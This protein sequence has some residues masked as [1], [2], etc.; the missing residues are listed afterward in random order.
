MRCLTHCAKVVRYLRFSECALYYCFHKCDFKFPIK[1]Y[2]AP[3]NGGT[4]GET[5]KLESVQIES[6]DIEKLVCFAETNNVNIVVVGPEQPLV[7]GLVDELAAR[8]RLDNNITPDYELINNAGHSSIW[9]NSN[10][11][12]N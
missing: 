2:V 8:V 3:G 10:S 6:N 11:S 1:V 4:Y 5:G 7:L 9:T 12:Q